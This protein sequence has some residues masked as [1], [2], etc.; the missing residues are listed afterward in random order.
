ME[1]HR[2]QSVSYGPTKNGNKSKI[3]DVSFSLSLSL[4]LTI[5]LHCI[6]VREKEKEREEEGTYIEG[7]CWTQNAM[8]NDLHIVGCIPGKAFLLTTLQDFSRHH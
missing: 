7:A 1:T 3:G 2:G 8:A 6:V 4:F 5:P